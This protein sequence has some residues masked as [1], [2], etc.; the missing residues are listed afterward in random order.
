MAKNVG[1]IVVRIRVKLSW[2]TAIKLR[3]AGRGL[4][5]A[6]MDPFREINGEEVEY[7]MGSENDD[8]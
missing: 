5:D 1:T 2:W 4:Y 6:L 7:D 8:T 3:I